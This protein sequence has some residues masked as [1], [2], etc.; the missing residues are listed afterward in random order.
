MSPKWEIPSNLWQEPP[1][2]NVSASVVAQPTSVVAAPQGR[3]IKHYGVTETELLMFESNDGLADRTFQGFF[4]GIALTCTIVDWS[5]SGLSPFHHALVVLGAYFGWVLFAATGWRAH[6]NK[7][8]QRKM[9][10]IVRRQR[11]NGNSGVSEPS[12]QPTEVTIRA[13]ANKWRVSVAT[14]MAP[15]RPD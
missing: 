5:Q 1:A 3:D 10:E 15:P 2:D 11:A 8:T 12:P 4:G 13:V 7:N 14:R 9:L 6:T